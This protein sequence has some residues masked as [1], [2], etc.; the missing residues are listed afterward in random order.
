M[1]GSEEKAG[2]HIVAWPEDAIECKFLGCFVTVFSD[3]KSI[4]PVLIS[5]P[6]GINS[7]PKTTQQ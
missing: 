4:N 7:N 1:W 5:C 6:D 2:E 3:Y